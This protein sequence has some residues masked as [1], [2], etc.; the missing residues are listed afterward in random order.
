MT[1]FEV[2]LIK[3]GKHKVGIIGLKNALEEMADNFAQKSD[4][5]VII[6]LLN[7]ISKANYIPDHIRE[8][9]GRAFL[10]EFRKFLGQSYQEEY[11]KELE[12]KI[13]GPGCARCDRIEKDVMDT[14]TKMDLA[15]D[16]EHVRDIK[17]IGKY[18]VM[19]TP[20]LLINDKVMC[21]GKVPSISKIKKWLEE[22]REKMSEAY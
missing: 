1:D 16:L 5:V 19:G 15:A 2:T 17:E 21:V 7:R 3:I 20:A 13:L 12:I 14:L 9:Y 22:A 10:R 6:E 8:D 18:G 4:D 11:S